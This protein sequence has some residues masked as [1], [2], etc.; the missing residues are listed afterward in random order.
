MNEYESNVLLVTGSVIVGLFT[1]FSIVLFFYYIF[2]IC[3]SICYYCNHR[4]KPSNVIPGE[5]RSSDGPTVNPSRDV[6]ERFP[7]QHPSTSIPVSPEGQIGVM[8]LFSYK[9]E[10][11]YYLLSSNKLW[12]IKFMVFYVSDINYPRTLKLL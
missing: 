2:I 9:F 3:H 11:L 12:I 4:N 5:I 8:F 7:V 10:R 1:L 6:I